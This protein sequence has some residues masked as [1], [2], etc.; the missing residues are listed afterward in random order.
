ML[1]TD[2][3]TRIPMASNQQNTS[4][5][6]S[7]I[8]NNLFCYATWETIHDLSSDHLPIKITINTKSKFRATDSKKTYT[9]YKKANWEN[10]TSEI[11]TALEDTTDPADV[12]SSNKIITNLI[13]KA[14]KHHIPKGKINSH[15]LLLPEN[16]RSKINE[17][18]KLRKK[19]S[20]NPNFNEMNKEINKLIQTHRSNLWKEKL[21][22]NWNHKI[23]TKKFWQILNN[24]SNKK[25]TQQTNRIITFKNSVKKS[26]IKK[27]QKALTINSQTLQ[28][29]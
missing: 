23:N 22:E 13:L 6:I 8:S 16:I 18:N 27:Y 21:N 29:M 17:R 4:P 15:H 19:D 25:P 20:K 26:K 11:E 7:A 9:N 5:D 3:P 24:L 10:F 28:N 12:H 14:D 2:N 1:N